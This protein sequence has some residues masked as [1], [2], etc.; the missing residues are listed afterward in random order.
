[1]GEVIGLVC[2]FDVD[3][4]SSSTIFYESLVN[5]F[6][7]NPARI[8][9]YHS[10][11]MEHGDGLTPELIERIQATNPPPT[12]IMTAALGSKDG[13]QVTAHK[14]WAKAK[15]ILSDIIITDHHEIDE[16]NLPKDAYAFINPKRPDCEFDGKDICGAVVALMLMAH[17]RKKLIDKAIREKASLP[18]M[19]VTLP[20]AAAATIADGSSIVSPVNR[21]I[22][23]AGV[24]RMNAGL[25]VCWNAFQ[26]FWLQKNEPITA[27]TIGFKLAPII[28]TASRMGKDALIGVKFFL[29]DSENEAKRHL[30]SLK[31]FNDDRKT[32]QRSLFN[33]AD[34]VATQQVQRDNT[35]GL[36]IFQPNGIHGIQGLVAASVAQK[37]GRPAI[38]FAP[39][40][41]KTTKVKFDI[42][43]KE[44][45]NV[46][47]FSKLAPVHE[48]VINN[49]EMIEVKKT[50]DKHTPTFTLYSTFSG[51]KKFVKE[52]TMNQ[53]VG[54]T[55]KSLF[56]GLGKKEH[57]FNSRMGNLILDLSVQNKPKL[58]LEGVDELI[59][60]AQS[61][62]GISI[63]NIFERIEKERPDVVVKC[64]GHE[65]AGS[66]IIQFDQ[67]DAFKETFDA[68][69]RQE[70][71]AKSIALQAC[72]YSDGEI[73][74]DRNLDL[75]IVDEL[76]Q[77]EPFG[78]GFE[79]P[80][81][82]FDMTVM[83]FERIGDTED[84]KLR[85]RWARNGV[86]YHVFWPKL[87]TNAEELPKV[88]A[89]AQLRLLCEIGDNY[90]R[91]RSIQ[92]T[93]VASI[94]AAQ[95]MNS[96]HEQTE[97]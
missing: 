41:N 33:A 91:N 88:F 58:Y 35:V 54:M 22:V 51:E 11:R 86:E 13:A 30:L 32:A 26:D 25:D 52:L 1:M 70:C 60:S 34:M 53:A 3:G 78:M 83:K 19:G 90:V 8:K 21:G 7:C 45:L 56:K 94:E 89:G 4:V 67:L 81:F 82:E 50:L 16:A 73:P 92:L 93:V 66:M 57:T 95:T 15:G 71:E 62:H 64:R 36:C 27:Q 2:D 17:V 24:K 37:Y 74:K 96:A 39:K 43:E 40:S 75:T 80:A 10:Y 29:S 72:Y 59:G 20:F 84:Y 6:G 69:V 42:I 87:G 28:H 63:R 38:V 76:N 65:T 61:V 77:L 55:T 49:D 48:V 14:K 23:H 47:I 12:L 5:V 44:H 97:R 31:A 85:G 18:S 9:V 79:R 68:F 46:D